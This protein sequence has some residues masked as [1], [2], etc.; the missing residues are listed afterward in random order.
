MHCY[1][2]LCHAPLTKP[3]FAT[4]RRLSTG[5]TQS[6]LHFHPLGLTAG[7]SSPGWK[8]KA[9]ATPSAKPGSDEAYREAPS[10][11]V[12]LADAVEHYA[13]R[14]GRIELLKMDCEG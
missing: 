9:A 7:S 1:A 5:C 11:F 2:W 13:P 14:G 6:R 8:L 3:C 10:A 4:T 12:T